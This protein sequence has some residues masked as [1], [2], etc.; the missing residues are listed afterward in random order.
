MRFVDRYDK[1]QLRDSII[2]KNWIST[3][4]GIRKLWG[5]LKAYEFKCLRPRILN[6]D[7]L[8]HFFKQI[9]SFEI[10]NKN[11]TCA[12][13]ESSFKTLLINNLT[14]PRTVGNNS[15]NKI[16]GSLL[17][18]LKDFICRAKSKRSYE[19]SL[20]DLQMLDLEL[21]MKPLEATH[22]NICNSIASRILN[23][24]RIKECDTCKNLLTDITK[25]DLVSNQNLLEAFNNADYM[26]T[27]QMSS[28][29]YRHHTALM[30]ET[31]LYT[32][33]DLRWLNCPQHNVLLKKFLV[34]HIVA[35]YIYKWCNDISDIL[36]EKEQGDS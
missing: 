29:C 11:P 7:P 31:E 2:L 19:R 25:S 30:L 23:N 6:Q 16:D 24:L 17:F 22:L 27:R 21:E 8:R 28:V 9:R 15:E 3:I 20:E 36:T 1:N 13:F 14:P 5:I 4:K 33:M 34:S 26:L 10:R 35:F 12:E 18:T 32:R